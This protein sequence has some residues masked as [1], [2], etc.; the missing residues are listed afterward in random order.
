MAAGLLVTVLT[1]GVCTCPAA[2]PVS[3]LSPAPSPSPPSD[4]GK[5]AH[6]NG[7]WWV[8]PAP[9]PG[10]AADARQYFILEGRPGTTLQDGLA[11]SNY[12]DHPITY[13]VY[14]ADGYNTPRDG[15]FAL[16]EHGHQMTG[17][18]S[19]VHTAFPTVT[20]PARTS[21]V[22]HRDLR[23]PDRQDRAA[24]AD[25]ARAEHRLRA[26]MEAPT[27]VRD[28]HG[29][30][31]GE[32]RLRLAGGDFHGRGFADPDSVAHGAGG[33]PDCVCGDRGVCDLEASQ[34][35]AAGSS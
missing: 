6:D 3:A 30:S 7:S 1:I 20:V 18:G 11:I 21:T 12:T 25:P 16:R 29:A 26:A 15:Q 2:A 33:S 13:D 10:A 19:W 14:G 23:H 5:V 22:V 8:Q 24:A 17:V 28:R 31:G 4:P 27:A 34:G 32:R 35:S 9:K